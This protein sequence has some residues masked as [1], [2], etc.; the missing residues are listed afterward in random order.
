MV[1]TLEEAPSGRDD[2]SRR[3]ER[4]YVGAQEK[5]NCERERVTRIICWVKRAGQVN[6]REINEHLEVLKRHTISLLYTAL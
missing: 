5:Q 3:G 2:Q 4:M 6:V 1:G